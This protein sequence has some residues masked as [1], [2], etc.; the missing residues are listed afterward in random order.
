MYA[1]TAARS[2]AA[3]AASRPTGR[4]QRGSLSAAARQPCRGAHRSGLGDCSTKRWAQVSPRAPRAPAADSHA[5]VDEPRC[6]HERAKDTSD[7]ARATPALVTVLSSA[8]RRAHP[9]AVPHAS[10]GHARQPPVS[11]MASHEAAAVAATPPSSAVTALRAVAT[12]VAG[13]VKT[14]PPMAP[15]K[16]RRRGVQTAA[17]GAAAAHVERSTSSKSGVG[18][19]D[20]VGEAI[21]GGALPRTS[22]AQERRRLAA[23]AESISGGRSVKIMMEEGGGVQSRHEPVTSV[24]EDGWAGRAGEWTQPIRLRPSD[25]YDV[26]L[27]LRGGT[28]CWRHA[29]GNS[30]LPEAVVVC[31]DGIAGWGQVHLAVPGWRWRCKK[32]KRD[33]SGFLPLNPGTHGIPDQIGSQNPIYPGFQALEFMFPVLRLKLPSRPLL[34][35][36]KLEDKTADSESYNFCRS[37]IESS[38]STVVERRDRGVV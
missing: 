7:A 32:K 28:R 23:M 11:S 1:A 33:T 16:A 14:I 13:A 17:A 34:D 27:V 9:P 12:R 30:P 15:S 25:R 36:Q 35:T 31:R 18:R 10:G 21:I 8:D 26:G 19:A 37:V 3:R 29:E 6:G 20:E 4:G 22:V 38:D 24:T 5:H 2:A